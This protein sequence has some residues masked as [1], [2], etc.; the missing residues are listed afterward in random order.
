MKF[1]IYIAGRYLIGSHLS[2]NVYFHEPALIRL[3]FIYRLCRI[4][5]PNGVAQHEDN[6]H[7]RSKSARP[8][9]IRWKDNILTTHPLNT[10]LKI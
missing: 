1:V 10:Y 7:K 3:D 4:P 6:I 8:R 9:R 5:H 2:V